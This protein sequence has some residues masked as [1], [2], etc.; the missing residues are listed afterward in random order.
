MSV[1]AN[2]AFC[3]FCGAAVVEHKAPK[4]E[5]KWNA[6]ALGCLAPVAS[7]LLIIEVLL[8]RSVLSRDADAN[9]ARFWAL[10]F[11]VLSFAAL[12]QFW[13]NGR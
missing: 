11:G 8:V 12:R 4:N 7:L 3:S 9:F 1:S 13:K 10:V 5:K 6:C 2:E